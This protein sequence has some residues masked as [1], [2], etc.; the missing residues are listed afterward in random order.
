VTMRSTLTVLSILAIVLQAIPATAQDTQY[1]T[2]QF[3][4][5]ANLLGG[6]VV[7]SISDLSSTFYNPG[8]LALTKDPQLVISTSAVRRTKVELED[9]VGRGIPLSSTKIGPAPSIVAIRLGW[10]PFNGQIAISYLERF[11]FDLDVVGRR[12]ASRDIAGGGV[13]AFSG[14]LISSSNLSEYWGGL[15]W[16]SPVLLDGMGLGASWYVAYRGQSGRTQALALAS[17]DTLGGSS[18]IFYDEFS[19]Y[20]IRTLFKIGA[21]FEWEVF[22]LGFT[23]T[24]PSIDLFGS[25]HTVVNAGVVLPDTS[26]AGAAPSELAADYQEGLDANFHSPMSI[27]GGLSYRFGERERGAVHFTAEYFTSMDQ[28]DVL[29]PEPFVAQTTGNVVT[30]KYTHEANHVFNWGIGAEFRPEQKMTFY[31][32][33][34]TDYS[35]R[36]DDVDRRQEISVSN[37]DIQHVSFGSAFTVRTL[38][39]TLGLS[40]G[41]GLDKSDRPIDFTASDPSELTDNPTKQNISYNSFKVLLGFSFPL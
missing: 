25:G 32:A 29:S 15:S 30:R 5:R 22:R 19:F 11:K 10:H 20:N 28:F 41:W 6:V 27:A 40:Y 12:I 3:G 21:S 2:D 33:Y 14:E 36:P 1:W 17:S 39:I 23:L 38:D 31:I 13:D 37:W 26:G 35:Y 8:M 16:A 9:G 18:A 7:G 24:T 4:T 34:I